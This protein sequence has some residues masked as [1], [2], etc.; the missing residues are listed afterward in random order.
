MGDR[1]QT[2][3]PSRYIKPGTKIN[4]TWSV[5]IPPS[6]GAIYATSDSWGTPRYALAV[7]GLAMLTGVWPIANGD[8]HRH[9]WAL[10]LG[11]DFTFT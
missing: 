3:K 8:Q 9:I 11:K 2:G 7:R 5:V 6:V 1:Q 10:W 4:S